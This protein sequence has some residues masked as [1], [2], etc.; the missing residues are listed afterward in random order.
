[1]DD[2]RWTETD[3]SSAFETVVGLGADA[4]VASLGR[5]A[6]LLASETSA[7]G[8]DGRQR[9]GQQQRAGGGVHATRRDFLANR[10]WARRL[11]V[12]RGARRGG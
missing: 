6:E 10:R 12:R 8:A 11:V 4:G 7:L 5:P 9:A 3:I 1:M 2:G